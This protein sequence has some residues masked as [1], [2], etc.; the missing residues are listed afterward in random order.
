PFFVARLREAGSLDTRDVARAAREG[1]PT[2]NAIIQ[3]A[4]S[5]IGAMLA[6]MVNFFNPSRILIGG[7]VAH[8]GPLMLASIRQSVYVRSLPLS[9]RK[10]RLDYTRLGDA[11]G[12]RG[13]TAL[14]C[15]EILRA[16]GQKA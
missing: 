16:G 5:A 12:L 4:G 1:D 7:G 13:A 3:D 15:M 10:L 14:A 9:T 8:I 2:A 11:A 6:S